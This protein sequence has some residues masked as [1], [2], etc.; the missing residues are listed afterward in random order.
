MSCWSLCETNQNPDLHPGLNP[1]I[2]ENDVEDVAFNTGTGKYEITLIRPIA[3]GEV[4]VITYDN[5][6]LDGTTVATG[7]FAY[8]PA[9][10]NK[11]GT[12]TEMDI[13]AV[14]DS[15]NGTD[16]L[17][18]ERADV[19]RDGEQGPTDVLRVLDLLNGA[20]AFKPWLGVTVDHAAPCP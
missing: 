7:R 10:V 17:A 20:G 5:T 14:I 8:H 2:G 9:D 13:L 18:N 16:P 3:H 15:L 12:S 11:T 1:P 6:A 4:A 19:D